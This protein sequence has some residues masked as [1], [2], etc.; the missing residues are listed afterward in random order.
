M[1]ENINY[2]LNGFYKDYVYFSKIGEDKEELI[3]A[4]VR[5]SLDDEERANI[6]YNG[7]W[8]IGEWLEDEEKFI[9]IL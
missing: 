7:V 9:V 8:Y 6:I 3:Q 4:Y 5:V 1:T 2:E